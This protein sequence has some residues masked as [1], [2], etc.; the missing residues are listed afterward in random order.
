MAVDASAELR[1]RLTDVRRQVGE[2]RDRRALAVRYA[3]ALND[4]DPRATAAQR[5]VRAVDRELSALS[6]EERELLERL[7]AQSGAGADGQGFDEHSFL[8]DPEVMRQLEQMSASK[9][10]VGRVNLGYAT[11]RDALVAQLGGATRMFAQDGITT[12]P[13]AARRGAFLG[14]VPQLRR[15]LRLL[16]LFPSAPMDGGSFDYVQESGP[17]DDA[18]ETVEGA[19]KPATEAIFTDAEAKA[20]TI[21]HFTKLQKASLADTPAIET[22]IRNRLQYGVLRRLERQLLSGD[23]VGENLRGIL[24]TT[25]V[26]LVEY[27]AGEL[28]ADQAL[29]GITTVLLSDA[30]PNFV[31]LNPR[32]WANALKAKAEGD[33][34]YFSAG[35]FLDTAERMWGAPAIP[36][37]AVAA[38]TAVV[39]DA[40]IGATV[41]VREGVQVLVS[42]ADSDDFTRNRV[43]LLGEGR[44]ALALWQPSAFCIVDLAA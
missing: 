18:A 35:P 6:D 15:P 2:A 44:F 27:A 24:N 14:V 32:D 16:D 33:G 21:A 36:S 20:K 40:T 38:G 5:D 9:M 13:D 1:E 4:D 41:F 34:H 22:A 43:T 19:V 31:A 10:P 25:G 28:A 11:S 37:A 42:D 26:G 7:G 23:G 29:E 30:V 3:D 8:R 39:G 17:L 12:V